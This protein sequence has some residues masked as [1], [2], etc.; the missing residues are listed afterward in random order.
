MEIT[1]SHPIPSCEEALKPSWQPWLS[2]AWSANQSLLC[3]VATSSLSTLH[4]TGSYQQIGDF[5]GY[6]VKKMRSSAPALTISILHHGLHSCLVF[7][8]DGFTTTVVYNSEQVL[9]GDLPS[10]HLR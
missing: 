10:S 7:I 8:H 4:V 6:K 1:S 9:L 2:G 5:T 3:Q